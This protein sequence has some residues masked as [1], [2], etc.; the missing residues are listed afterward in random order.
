MIEI[1]FDMEPS[2]TRDALLIAART[3][4]LVV[5]PRS[6]TAFSVVAPD[7]MKVFEL[8]AA[9]VSVMRARER[10]AQ[11]AARQAREAKAARR[12]PKSRPTARRAPRKKGRR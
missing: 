3:L 4:Q 12:K 7:R 11:R 9:T 6:D 2:P 8:G 10:Q 1:T 5:T